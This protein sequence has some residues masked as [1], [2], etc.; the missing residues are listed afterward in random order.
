MC[1]LKKIIIT[2]NI[3]LNTQFLI[4]SKESFYKEMIDKTDILKIVTNSNKF[5]KIVS[6]TRHAGTIRSY[7]HIY[8]III[9]RLIML[10]VSLRTTF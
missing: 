7:I 6:K 8:I 4:N 3:S 2:I 10:I 1:I 9:F 5:L